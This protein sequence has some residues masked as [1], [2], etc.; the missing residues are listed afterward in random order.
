MDWYKQ[1]ASDNSNV[2][3]FMDSI[4]K[5]VEGRDQPV[6][7]IGTSG[8]TNLKQIYFQCQIHASKCAQTMCSFDCKHFPP[9]EWIAGATCMYIANYLVENSKSDEK[10]F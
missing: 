4:G 2:V 9:G 8:A 5:S 10:V 1:L 7:V 6:V 3:K